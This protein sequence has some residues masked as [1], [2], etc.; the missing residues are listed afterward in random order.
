[1]PLADRFH[2]YVKQLTGHEPAWRTVHAT[3][4]PAYLRQRFEVRQI[5]ML[6]QI[7]L[8]AMLK[9]GEALA[10]LQLHKQLKQLQDRCVPQAE[11]ACLVAE[12]LPPH[13]RRRLVELGQAFVVPGRQLFWPAIGSAETVR[14]PQRLRPK[15][16]EVLVPVAQQLLIALLLRR[17]LPPLTIGSAAEALGCSTASVSQAVKALE[18]SALVQSEMRGRERLFDLMASPADVWRLAQPLLRT[19]VRQ[20]VRVLLAELPQTLLLRAGESALATVTDMGDPAE[21]VFAITSRYWGKYADVPVHIPVPDTGTC[22][23]ELWRYP[24]EPTAAHGCVD[25]LSLYLSLRDARDERLQLA[26]QA[27]ME[28]IEW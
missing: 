26:L 17:L 16:V 14:R 18:A 9:D 8:A 19:P 28:R 12:E 25:P 11:G 21:Q 13:V 7:W 2:A 27:L 3:S 22:V 23:V 4:L 24:P 20:R 5:E 6:G 10:P 15:P 1:M